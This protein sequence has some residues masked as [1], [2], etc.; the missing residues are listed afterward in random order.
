M[1]DFFSDLLRNGIYHFLISLIL[2]TFL[3]VIICVVTIKKKG[4]KWFVQEIQKQIKEDK[5]FFDKPPI[6]MNE[7]K[8][9]MERK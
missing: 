9:K 7:Q 2:I 4:W 1:K 5:E 3:T 6:E 8:K